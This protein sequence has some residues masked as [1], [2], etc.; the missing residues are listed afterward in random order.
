MSSYE[1]EEQFD[2]SRGEGGAMYNRGD[3]VVNGIAYFGNNVAQ[4]RQFHR[5]GKQGTTVSDLLG[6]TSCKVCLA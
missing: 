4:V 3:I 1:W 2:A 6:F 5:T